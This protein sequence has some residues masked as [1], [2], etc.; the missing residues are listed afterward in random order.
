MKLWHDSCYMFLH[1][2]TF[3]RREPTPSY[4]PMDLRVATAIKSECPEVFIASETQQELLRNMEYFRVKGFEEFVLSFFMD[5]AG[6]KVM[7]LMQSFRFQ[8]S[9]RNE[10]C[11]AVRSLDEFKERIGMRTQIVHRFSTKREMFREGRDFFRKNG[12]HVCYSMAIS[13][14]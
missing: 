1:I 7:L 5:S 12:C 8:A 3:K 14:W 4:I 11:S 13:T 6:C 2:C 9:I 10:S